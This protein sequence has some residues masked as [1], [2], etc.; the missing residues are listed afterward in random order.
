VGFPRR[1]Q[2]GSPHR[3][4]GKHAWK[5]VNKSQFFEEHK[6]LPQA[7]QVRPCA[8]LLKVKHFYHRIAS[9]KTLL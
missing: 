3:L 1:Y 7:E 2:G 5:R 8:G 9:R 4:D 6:P